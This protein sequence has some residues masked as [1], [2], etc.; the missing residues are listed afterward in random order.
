V[1]TGAFQEGGEGCDDRRVVVGQQ[2]G[3]AIHHIQDYSEKII[4]SI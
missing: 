3:G 1:K 4:N 2:K